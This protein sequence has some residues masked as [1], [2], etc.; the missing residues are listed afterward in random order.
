MSQSANR[1]ILVGNLARDP[2]LAARKQGEGKIANIALGTSES[3]NARNTGER[4]EE[5]TVAPC[6][7]LQRPSLGRD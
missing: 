6:C 2:E 3:W 5:K 1:I 4:R 7:V